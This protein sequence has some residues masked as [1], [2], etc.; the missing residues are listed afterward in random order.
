MELTSI[1]CPFQTKDK[2]GNLIN[3]KNLCVRVS[4]GSSGEA[5]CHKC[6]LKFNFEVDSQSNYK[7][8]VVVQRENIKQPS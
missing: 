8:K 6:H 5:W 1:R 2:Y 3:C 7:A 4:S